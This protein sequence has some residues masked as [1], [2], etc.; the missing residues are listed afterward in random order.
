MAKRA[1]GVTIRVRFND[2]AKVAG[3]LKDGADA[4]VDKFLADVDADATENAP[5]R[6]GHLKNAK[7]REARRIHWTAD[8]AAYVNY[9]TRFMAANGFVTNAVARNEPGAQEAYAELAGRIG[10]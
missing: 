4:I 2:C 10:S 3:E 6:T 8:Y 9:G 7:E 5:V 1:G